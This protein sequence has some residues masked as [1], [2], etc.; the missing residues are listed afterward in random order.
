MDFQIERGNIA[1]C[2]TEAIVLPANGMLREGSGASHAIF[3]AAGRTD[4][5]K[6][7]AGIKTPVGVGM[8]VPTAGYN[9]RADFIIHAVVT[10]WVDG[11]QNEYELLGSAYRSSL[12]IADKMKCRSIAFPLLAAGNN[13]FD[14]E[15]A[16]K[17]KRACHR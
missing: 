10:K 15:L 2:D 1:H 16:F 4:L 13:G 17:K 8:A 9:L 5:R 14:K 11:N 7:C 12:E 3:D 6:A